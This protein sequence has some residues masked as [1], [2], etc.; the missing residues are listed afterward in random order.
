MWKL[1][2]RLREKAR[3]F[4]DA[5]DVSRLRGI[6]T[7]RDFDDKIT[8]HYCGFTGAVDYYDR[9]AAA[10]V[11]DRITVP[12]FILHARNDPFIRI[13]PETRQKILSNP[14]IT[15]IETDDGGHCSFLTNPD[16]DDG[17]W[18]EQQVLEFLR[19]F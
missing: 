1:R 14:N 6:M 17:R 13:L 15:F 19:K 12:T 4:P 18:A 3:L 10:N 8:A 5:F 9:A 16:G 7:L 2:R 11:L